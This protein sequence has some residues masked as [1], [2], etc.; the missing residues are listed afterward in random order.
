M[1]K[2]EVV[3]FWLNGANEDWEFAQEIWKSGK[4]LYNALFF[5]QLALEKILKALHYDLKDEHPLMT[6]DLSLLARKLELQMDPKLEAD[7]KKISSF[8]ISA[9]YDDYKF[10]FRRE[11]NVEFVTQWI[12]RSDEIKSYLLT[13]FSKK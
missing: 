1:K 6:H 2:D 7:L 10:K 4:R 3:Q 11:A 5:T 13:L 8:N 12:K 9:R